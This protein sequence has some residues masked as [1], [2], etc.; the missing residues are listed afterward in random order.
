[1]RGLKWA[2]DPGGFPETAA[3]VAAHATQGGNSVT[4]SVVVCAY[5]LDRWD[6]LVAAVTSLQQQSRPPAEIVVVIDHNPHL[7]ERVDATWPGIIV[8][9]NEE[10]RGLSGARNTA[11]R[12]ASSD[13]IAF[14]DDDARAEP[15]WLERL[16]FAYSEEQ[17]LG[18]GGAILPSWESGRPAW[19]PEEFDWVVGCTYKGMPLVRARQRNLIGANMSFRRELFGVAGN[20]QT[21]MGRI[22]TRPLGCEETELCIRGAQR[23]PGSYYVYEPAARVHHRVPAIRTTWRYFVSRCYSE[24]LSKAQVS[25]R[26]GADAGLASERHYA[27]RTLPAGVI[28]GITDALT[29]GKPGGLGRAVAIISGLAITG[30]GYLRGRVARPPTLPGSATD[31]SEVGTEGANRGNAPAEAS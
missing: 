3:N 4:V 22:G 14:L 26:V 13:F 11:V 12:A 7:F 16:L 5:T 2:A 24:G 19:F 18:A 8:L 25:D 28:R 9:E 20:F 23:L 21:D 15:D 1:M 31:T 17:V 30:V 29:G 6:D 27:T 10:S